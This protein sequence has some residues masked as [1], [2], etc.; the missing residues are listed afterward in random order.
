[1]IGKTAR[2]VGDFGP[3]GDAFQGT[4]A[5]HGERWRAVSRHPLKANESCRVAGRDGLTLTVEP[6]PDSS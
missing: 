1:M 5:V 2:V 4:V 3:R 6:P